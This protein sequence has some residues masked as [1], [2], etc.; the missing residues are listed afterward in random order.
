MKEYTVKIRTTLG[1]ACSRTKCFKASVWAESAGMAM[2]EFASRMVREHPTIDW[3]DNW[4]VECWCGDK[5]MTPSDVWIEEIV[6]L[7]N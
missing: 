7:P 4:M 1:T 3:L 5:D 2:W 6:D